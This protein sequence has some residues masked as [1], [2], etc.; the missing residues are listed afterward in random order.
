MAPTLQ[1]RKTAA[2]KF[3]STLNADYRIASSALILPGP[4][5]VSIISNSRTV[6]DWAVE[7]AKACRNLQAIEIQNNACWFGNGHV[8]RVLF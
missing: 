5:A 4:I 1:T 3:A 8:V 2:A 6:A 7:K